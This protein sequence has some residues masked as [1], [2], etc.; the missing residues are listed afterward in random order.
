VLSSWLLGFA[1]ARFFSQRI[2]RRLRREMPRR[3]VANPEPIAETP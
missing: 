2:E 1:V 3:R